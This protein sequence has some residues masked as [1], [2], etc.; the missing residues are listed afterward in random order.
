MPKKLTDQQGDSE[1]APKGK[2]T[3]STSQ[4]KELDDKA[5]AFKRTLGSSKPVKKEKACEH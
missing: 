1:A 3:L 4:K 2:R 5:D